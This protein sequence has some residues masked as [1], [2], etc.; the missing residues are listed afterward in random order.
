MSSNSINQDD[1][2]NKQLLPIY[3]PDQDTN[4]QSCL[5]ATQMSKGWKSDKIELIENFRIAPKYMEESRTIELM[6]ILIDK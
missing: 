2:K 4:P 1:L 6:L 3:P 5:A